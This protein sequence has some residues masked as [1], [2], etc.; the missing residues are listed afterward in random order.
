MAKYQDL[1]LDQMKLL[2]PNIIV[3]CGGGG[4]IKNFVIEKFLKENPADIKSETDNWIYYSPIN[5]VWVVDSYHMNPMGNSTDKDLYENIM[6][7]LQDGMKIHKI[8]I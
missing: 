1:I 6:K 5:D 7:Y 3:S 8:K 4:I 2:A